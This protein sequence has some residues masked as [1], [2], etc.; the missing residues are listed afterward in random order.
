MMSDR[1]G[2]ESH[3]SPRHRRILP[4]RHRLSEIGVA[5]Y[6]ILLLFVTPSVVMGALFAYAYPTTRE[7]FSYAPAE[8]SLMTLYMMHF[9][10]SDTYHL[11]VNLSV[12]WLVG[13]LTLLLLCACGRKRLYY[14]TFGAFLSLYPVVFAPVLHASV[15]Y[16]RPERYATIDG[17]GSSGILSAL[18]A[19]LGIA[20]IVYVRDR[21]LPSIPVFRLSALIVLSGF[22]TPAFA[23]GWASEI[24]VAAGIA[25]VASLGYLVG[26]AYS[27]SG[28]STMTVWRG[29]AVLGGVAVFHVW[30]LRMLAQKGPGMGFDIH[31]M[32]YIG[33]IVLAG[34]I[35]AVSEMN[36]QSGDLMG[37]GSDPAVWTDRVLFAC[38]MVSLALI[39]WPLSEAVGPLLFG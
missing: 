39:A 32:G 36:R 25:L 22:V 10:H 11:L 16:F 7:P 15:L 37:G 6:D 31:L 38:V 20:T 34:G 26:R 21:M 12:L 23:R 30:A 19:F 18:V 3:L 5:W 35:L 28:Q 2:T 33:G 27:V 14:Y 13:G 17:V 8:P 24:R 9:A 1:T 29:L 4:A